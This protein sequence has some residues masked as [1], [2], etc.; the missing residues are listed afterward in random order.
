MSKENIDM[1]Q[2]MIR[3]NIIQVDSLWDFFD[4]D[5]ADP[6]DEFELLMYIIS[7]SIEEWAA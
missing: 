1:L 3:D 5:S 4:L 6:G 2:D 7:E